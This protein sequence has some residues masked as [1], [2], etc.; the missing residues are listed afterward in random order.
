MI[1][2]SQMTNHRKKVMFSQSKL[3]SPLVITTQKIYDVHSRK[4]KKAAIHSCSMVTEKWHALKSPPKTRKRRVISPAQLW[5]LDSLLIDYLADSGCYNSVVFTRRLGGPRSIT[6]LL[7]DSGM[8]T[9]FPLD[10]SVL[11]S[12][13]NSTT[14]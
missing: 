8:A 11:D 6:I 4:C 12:K 3:A 10:I 1:E 7:V 5:A 14:E 13:P 2:N 9:S